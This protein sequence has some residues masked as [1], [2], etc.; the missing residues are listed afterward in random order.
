MGNFNEIQKGI[1]HLD[2]NYWQDLRHEETEESEP[3]I[4]NMNC[5]TIFNPDELPK[6]VKINPSIFKK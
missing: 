1:P 4:V 5:Q 2:A 6:N 3:N